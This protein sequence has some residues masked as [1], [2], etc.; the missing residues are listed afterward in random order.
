MIRL[1]GSARTII[2][3]STLALFACGPQAKQHTGDDDDGADAQATSCTP[4]ATEACY[5]GAA[6]TQG[7]GP[8]TGGTQTCG[9]DGTWGPCEGE[10]VPTGEI[11]ANGVDDNCNGTIDEDV[12]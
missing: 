5:S 6:G 7:V 2:V 3:M 11:C 12:D 8:C 9:S 1:I 10:V 4:G